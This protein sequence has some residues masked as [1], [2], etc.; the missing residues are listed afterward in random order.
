MFY[1]LL[2]DGIGGRGTKIKL[3]EQKG[4]GEVIKIRE[5]KE[6]QVDMPIQA[7]WARSAGNSAIKKY[8]LFIINDSKWVYMKTL[9][10]LSW[11]YVLFAFFIFIFLPKLNCLNK[12]GV[13]K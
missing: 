1:L 11:I 13:G 10:S 9:K 5:R 2:G 4:S 6:I 8:V 3:L 12:K 7:R